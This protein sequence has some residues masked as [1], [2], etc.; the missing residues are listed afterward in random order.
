MLKVDVQQST[1]IATLK[2][3]VEKRLFSISGTV[4]S[5]SKRHVLETYQFH[6]VHQYIK[7]I[8]WNFVQL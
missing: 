6:K 2:K 3:I 5:W 8:S 4:S 7:E 1:N